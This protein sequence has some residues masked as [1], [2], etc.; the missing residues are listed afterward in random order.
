MPS[1]CSEF[2]YLI[3][4]KSIYSSNDIPSLIAY[5]KCLVNEINDLKSKS[6]SLENELESS[7]Q[8]LSLL[9]QKLSDQHE[10]W[11]K[12]LSSLSKQLDIEV[13][14]LTT[15][16][17]QSVDN[18]TSMFETVQ[19]GYADQLSSISLILACAGIFF[20]I[21]LGIYKKREIN[22]LKDETLDNVRE[23][24]RKEGVVRSLVESSLTESTV[25]ALLD[26]RLNT[27][28]N[29]LEQQIITRIQDEHL[30]NQRPNSDEDQLSD[31]I[32]R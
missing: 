7:Q 31:I 28:A 8:E 32:E 29:G 20:F 15:L 30:Y 9:S 5:N 18:F 21:G 3:D 17:E 1:N 25:T 19:T 6:D 11:N 10:T 2:N 27:I 16:Q 23:T 12:D 14:S 24:L 4:R 13:Q 26:E 22:Q